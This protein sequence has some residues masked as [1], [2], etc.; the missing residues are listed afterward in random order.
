MYT[1]VAF[2]A[3]LIG[4]L[5]YIYF[6]WNFG[7]WIKRGINGAKPTILLGNYPSELTQ[8]R[9]LTYE[10]DDYYREYKGKEEA[11]GVFS[12]RKPALAVIN[13]D[14]GKQIL[15]SN[16]KG[17]HDNP[18]VELLGGKD[19]DP[20]MGRNPFFLKGQEWK[21]KRSEITPAFTL[22]RIKCMF[23]NIEN[24]AKLMIAYLNDKIK[25]SSDGGKT[26]VEGKELSSCFTLEVVSNCIYGLDSGA[27]TDNPSP[28]K[29]Y[30][31]TIFQSDFAMIVYFILITFFPILKKVYTRP[32]VSKE[33]NDYFRD[34]MR[35]AIA[36]RKEKN[37]QRDDYLNYLLEMNKKKPMTEI[38]MAA[39]TVTFFLDGYETSS[40]VIAMTLHELAKNPRVQQKLRDEINGSYPLN[41]DSIHALP[42]LDQ[43]I[44][45][46]LRMHPPLAVITR[47]ST[48]DTYITTSKDKK[49]KI[50]KDLTVTIPAWSFHH[51]PEYYDYPE[52]FRPERFDPE[53]GGTKKYHDMGVFLP[54]GNGPRICLGMKFALTQMK[55]CISELV[56]NFT[57]T[58]N[59]KSSA[60]VIYDPKTFINYPIGGVW[61][62]LEPVKPT[63]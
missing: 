34:L 10:H 33:V 39:H 58:L 56:R 45:E 60:D 8:K 31:S 24:V 22:A 44:H 11:I 14:I 9:N 30:A 7:Y 17:F 19:T 1:E 27:F 20:L 25:K 47:L 3:G 18:F 28:L 50:D 12:L 51:D 16:F 35:Q 2:A 38:E 49:I 46:S 15:V 61:V 59:E 57:L 29:K 53:N 55:V 26:V 52:E 42:Y 13:P 41:F 40:I 54:F 21:D 4:W 23:P 36:L 48:E 32:F 6:R 63:S 43:V 62:N 5:V 37:I